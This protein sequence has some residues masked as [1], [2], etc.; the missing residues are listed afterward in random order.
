MASFVGID[1]GS[2]AVKVAVVRTAYRKQQLVGL[3]CVDLAQAAN[4]ED[5]VKTAVGLATGGRGSESLATA[6]DG[7]RGAVRVVGLP[8]SVAKQIREVLP[9]ELDSQVPFDMTEVTFDHRVLG[10]GR[11]AGAPPEQLQ[12]LVA[13]AKIE[14]VR[15]RIDLVKRAAAH[16][17]ERVSV[18]AFPLSNLVPVV[19]GLA[20][21]VVAIVDLGQKAS[22]LLVLK[23]G[24]PVFARTLSFG[25]EGLPQSASRLAR[26]LR[27]SVAAYRAA[28]GESPGRLFLTGGG[29]FVSGA[30]RFLAGELE[31]PVEVLPSPALE[32]LGPTPE[33]VAQMP[34]FSK[35]VGLA[36]GLGP[37]PLGMNLRRGP[38][39]FERG[40]AWVREKIPLV[41]GLSAAILVSFL[42]SAW[43]Q[44]YAKGKERDTL[45]HALA[46]VTKE[47]LG[48]E[49]QS[50]SRAQE[51]LSK[52]TAINDE[53]PMPHADSF[54][55]MVKLSEAI[56]ES[57]VHDI[58]ELDIQKGHVIIHGIVGTI[59]DAQAIQN[60]L[61]NERC[62]QD[63]KITRT[64]Q[65]VGG[66]RQKYQLE[67]D[68]KC[69][70]DVKGAKKPAG[71]GSSAPA[72]SASGGK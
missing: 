16:E 68:V 44:L 1:I 43:A 56:P 57:M 6:L 5:A 69:P 50:A 18:G 9:F 13:A 62:F 12:V 72:G 31:M 29:A 15:A 48:E 4:V 2:V 42:F 41:A 61:K 10:P 7:S 35:A 65:V 14:D 39:A 25:T 64:S 34:R 30:E 24:E 66:D 38:L 70:E 55:V 11:N 52:Q 54:D 53:D 3:A 59:P 71:A 22:E 51:L 17:P 49:T 33:L 46:S 19:P 20:D 8:A 21:G 40:F 28:G 58:E 36:L 32:V 26:E 27:V 23:G 37:K 63:V 45:E 47:V 60:S 67:L